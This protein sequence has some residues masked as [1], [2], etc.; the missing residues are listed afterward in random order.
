MTFSHPQ[1]ASGQCFERPSVHKHHVLL[2]PAPEERRRLEA[3]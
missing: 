1:P 2:S 3:A